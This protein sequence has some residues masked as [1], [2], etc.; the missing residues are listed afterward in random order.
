MS[1]IVSNNRC[2]EYEN[3]SSFFIKETVDKWMNL[4]QQVHSCYPMTWEACGRL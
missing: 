3:V 1:R 2:M 4:C